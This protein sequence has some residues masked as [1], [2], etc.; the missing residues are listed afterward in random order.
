MQRDLAIRSI[1]IARKGLDV[2]VKSPAYRE[3][4]K[5]GMRLL[6]VFPVVISPFDFSGSLYSR[7]CHLCCLVPASFG[8]TLVCI[9]PDFSV[10]LHF[11]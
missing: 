3:G 10:R 4:M 7:D 2:T 6:P 8:T 1:Q 9:F 11:Y 5:Y